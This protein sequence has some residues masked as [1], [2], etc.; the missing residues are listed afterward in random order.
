VVQDKLY[1][2]GGGWD[3]IKAGS[4][5]PIQQHMAIAVAFRVPWNETNQKHD[6]ELEIVDQDGES[7]VKINGMIEVGRPPGTPLGASQRVQLA[8][9]TNIP[10]P[11]AGTYAI[12]A[13]IEGQEGKRIAFHVAAATT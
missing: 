3:V 6:V 4:E 11:R 1:I 9:D 5:F 8:V 13:R 7:L 10:I 2:L 12:I